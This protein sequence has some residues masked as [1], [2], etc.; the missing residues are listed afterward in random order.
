MPEGDAL[1]YV[2]LTCALLLANPYIG[3]A[4]AS[5]VAARPAD[6]ECI[7]ELSEVGFAFGWSSLGESWEVNN[8]TEDL[9][10]TGLSEPSE[11]AISGDAGPPQ[12]NPYPMYINRLS[13]F[14]F[15]WSNVTD[16]EYMISS[17]MRAAAREYANNQGL[18]RTPGEAEEEYTGPEQEN[19]TIIYLNRIGFCFGWSTNADDM[20][21]ISSAMQVGYVAPITVGLAEPPEEAITGDAG[22]PQEN[23]AVIY[24]NGIGFCFGW[25]AYTDDKY[26][27]AS[28][29]S[30]GTLHALGSGWRDPVLSVA[31]TNPQ[32]GQYLK[33]LITI[34][35]EVSGLYNISKVEFYVDDELV[36][37]DTGPPWEYEWDTTSWGEGI[38]VVRVVAYNIYN[39]TATESLRVFVDNT[40]P[41]VQVLSPSGGS[42]VR[43]AVQL[44]VSINDASLVEAR[45]YIN[46]TL[47][48]TWTT[49]GT[50]TCEWNTTLWPD[51]LYVLRLVAID[52]CDNMAEASTRVVVDNTA[53]ILEFMSH[54]P[55][56]PLE[57]QEVVVE[58]RVS[59]AASGIGAVT[60]WYRVNSSSWTSIAMTFSNGTWRATIPGQP[61]GSVV[62]YYVEAE[63][64]AGNVIK[65][66]VVSYEVRAKGVQPPPGPPAG[67]AAG[68]EAWQIATA[69]SVG[70]AL[71]A[72][73][74]YLLRR[75]RT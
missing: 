12:E 30:A 19:P 73:A 55:E 26:R 37:T 28:S 66:D 32:E 63:D 75:R 16:E 22:P 1:L 4:Q 15:I 23:P 35:A 43:E 56:E 18:V 9:L 11:E 50:Y 6:A 61:A 31:I 60:L 42:Y 25:S 2:L 74:S 13:G 33:G 47:V 3:L 5:G 57:G 27:A 62:E 54:T 46:D 49:N 10:D 14:C 24:L 40:P 67:G 48:A 7:M 51:G 44:S 36:F 20:I 70:G 34:S 53:P 59:D 45:L 68:P 38:H 29:V 71:V 58:V 69:A 64:E 21:S 65:S 41:R 72:V 17:D 8:E 52:R 39:Y